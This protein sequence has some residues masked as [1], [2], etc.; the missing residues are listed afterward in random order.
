M[1]DENISGC[2]ADEFSAILVRLKLSRKVPDRRAAFTHINRIIDGFLHNHRWENLPSPS[3]SRKHL[4]N[5]NA[6]ARKLE[7]LLKEP[8]GGTPAEDIKADSFRRL[9]YEAGVKPLIHAKEN[10]NLIVKWSDAAE[11]AAA[12]MVG[13]ADIKHKGNIAIDAFICDLYFYWCGHFD[14]NPTVWVSE[15][16][17]SSAIIKF[18]MA[19]KDC[20]IAKQPAESA[21]KK[22]LSRLK[23]QSVKERLDRV[24]KPAR[25]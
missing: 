25:R 9:A 4:E 13:K 24:R 1:N 8:L 12:S 11:K 5:I 21:A 7:S 2:T 17:G 19:L 6:A 3:K 15:T 16:G 22:A 23:P 20:V 18:A 10:V 14:E